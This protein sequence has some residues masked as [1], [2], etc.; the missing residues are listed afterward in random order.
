MDSLAPRRR[1]ARRAHRSFHGSALATTTRSRTAGLAARC[2][3]LDF[4]EGGATVSGSVADSVA[5]CAGVGLSIDERYCARTQLRSW[6]KGY[7]NSNQMQS[8]MKTC[9]SVPG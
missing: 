6:V 1:S 9:N 3:L 2:R 8:V 5:T 4:G 7:D